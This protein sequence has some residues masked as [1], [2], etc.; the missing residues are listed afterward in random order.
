MESIVW[1]VLVNCLCWG[2]GGEPGKGMREKGR[3]GE[4]N[5]EG[6]ERGRDGRGREEST[7]AQLEQV[8]RMLYVIC[9]GDL[10]VCPWS[11]RLAVE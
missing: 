8:L 9:Q 7:V 10:P 3:G 2:G 6:R 4:E 11:L 5:R 1:S